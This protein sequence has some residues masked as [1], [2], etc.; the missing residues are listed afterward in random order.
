M[1]QSKNSGPLDAIP[2]LYLLCI[3]AIF[4]FGPWVLYLILSLIATYVVAII[5]QKYLKLSREKQAKIEDVVRRIHNIDQERIDVQNAWIQAEKQRGNYV[6]DALLYYDSI[7]IQPGTHL[8]YKP[9]SNRF[10]KQ[11]TE[12]EQVFQ[13]LLKLCERERLEKQNEFKI[14][15]N[16][17]D[18][19]SLEEKRINIQ[20]AWIR[21]EKRRKGANHLESLAY[22]STISDA[23]G[24]HSH[25]R[26]S[27]E[28]KEDQLIETRDI[29]SQLRTLF[30]NEHMHKEKEYKEYKNANKGYGLHSGQYYQYDYN[31]LKDLYGL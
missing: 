25:Y 29:I 5:Y 4:I 3:I 30:E 10:K 7:D 27:A 13:Q 23:P 26:P 24:A 22:Y 1:K 15:E 12:A 19:R 14:Q 8:D 6:R 17:K 20:E 28:K 21:L 11:L 2:G 18:I 9:K 31:Y 16:L